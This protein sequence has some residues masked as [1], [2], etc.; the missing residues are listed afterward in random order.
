VGRA[1]PYRP[2]CGRID[3]E[4]EP[5]REANRA[6]AAQSVLAHTIAGAADGPHHLPRQVAPT[7]E[8]I[9]QNISGGRVGDRVDGEVAAGEILVEARS[10]RD[11]RVAPVGLDIAAKGGHLV[12]PAGAVDHADRPELDPHRNRPA[13]DALHL[14]RRRRGGE[15]PVEVWV[16]E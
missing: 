9:V 1:L 6:Q 5:C 10:E 2:P 4:S 16:A 12:H 11:D 3:R 14:L 13:E 7:V 8:R 15:I